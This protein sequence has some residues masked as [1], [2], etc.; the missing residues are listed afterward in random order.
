MQSWHCRGLRHLDSTARHLHLCLLG[1]VP[2]EKGADHD[3]LL[4]VGKPT[5][6]CYNACM[7]ESISYCFECKRPLIEIDNRGK[8]LRGCMTC[9]IL[10]SLTGGGAVKLSVEDLQALQQL[11]RGNDQSAETLVRC[12]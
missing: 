4:P 12:G 6:H 3:R 2:N 10:W 9:N 5:P 7:T 11:R 8:R 1:H